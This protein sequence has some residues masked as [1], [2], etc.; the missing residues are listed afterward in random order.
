[1]GPYTLKFEDNGGRIKWD[2]LDLK[3]CAVIAS[4]IVDGGPIRYV[5]ITSTDTAEEARRRVY[6]SGG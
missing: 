2:G 3:K 4:E 6:G 1:M 5:T